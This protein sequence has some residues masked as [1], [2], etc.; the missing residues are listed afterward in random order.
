MPSKLRIDSLSAEASALRDLIK[1]SEKYG[2]YVGSIQYSQRLN[3]IEYEIEQLRSKESPLASVALYF[4]GKP[5]IGSRGIAADF[6]S[7]A[8]G[9][10]QEI[11]SKTYAKVEL[12]SLG[13]RGRIPLKGSTEL[14]VTG[15]T[16]GSFGFVLDELVDQE[17]LHD[18]ALKTIVHDVAGLLLE[19][20]SVNDEDFEK[21]AEGL[22]ARTLSALRI[23]FKHMDSSEASI[24]IVEGDQDFT[25]DERAVHRGRVR[26]EA[27]QIDESTEVVEGI[28]RGFL[29]EHRRFELQLD[30]GEFIY[31]GATTEAAEY[32]DMSL[33]QGVMVLGAKCRASIFK[34]VVTPINKPPREIYRLMEFSI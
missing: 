4:S 28:M 27:T 17:E 24:R 10:F 9:S 23:F 7:K 21:A 18:T 11:V 13:E 19:I 29:P 6:A 31:G 34:R 25:L 26:T 33:K 15:L 32:F 3:A 22:D 8:L 20:G 2:D 1:D 14:M 30:N 5:V 16:H 12:G